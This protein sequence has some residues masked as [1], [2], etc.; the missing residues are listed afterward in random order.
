M[1]SLRVILGRGLKLKLEIYLIQWLLLIWLNSF[2]I[3]QEKIKSIFFQ[4]CHKLHGVRNQL[5]CTGSSQTSCKFLRHFF[6]FPSLLVF[7][8]LQYGRFFILVLLGHGIEKKGW[9]ISSWNKVKFQG[10]HK[11][12][13]YLLIEFYLLPTLH[14]IISGISSLILK[15]VVPILLQI[16]WIFWNTLNIF[17][18][19]GF[20]GY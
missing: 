6:T 9:K 12:V 14:S 18:L 3:S 10:W 20:E 19:N 13:Q 1:V 4:Y 8:T 2:W 11:S 5:S 7:F 16:S 15:I 17:N